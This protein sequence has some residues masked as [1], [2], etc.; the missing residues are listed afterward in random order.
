MIFHYK[1]PYLNG[2]VYFFCNLPSYASK[3]WGSMATC[4]S[5]TVTY[6]L[7]TFIIYRKSYC[8]NACFYIFSKSL[9]TSY[10][11]TQLHTNLLYILNPTI[12]K[13]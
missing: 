4:V 2:R 5:V 3:R 10:T 8:Y 13:G 12:P 11:V 1:R 6:F 9:K 7:Q